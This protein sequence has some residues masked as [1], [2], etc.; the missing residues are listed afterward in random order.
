MD[1]GSIGRISGYDVAI[2]DYRLHDMTGIEIA[3]YL[4]AF[5]SDTPMVLVSALDD[6]EIPETNWPAPIAKFMNKKAGCSAILL[7]ALSLA[8]WKEMGGSPDEPARRNARRSAR[9]E[10]PG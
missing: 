3:E 5:F 7:A 2:I 4:Q 1:L 10:R 6:D 9:P 8:S